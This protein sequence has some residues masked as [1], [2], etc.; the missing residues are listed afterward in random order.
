MSDSPDESQ[1]DK[2]ASALKLSAPGRLSG[3]LQALRRQVDT[4]AEGDLDVSAS[5][6][7]VTIKRLLAEI[8]MLLRT[9]DELRSFLCASHE[10]PPALGSLSRPA[11]VRELARRRAMSAHEQVA[12]TVERRRIRGC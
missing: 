8:D 1:T 7:D 3:Y 12:E 6:A 9:D 4:I 2:E 10:I 11:A 5:L